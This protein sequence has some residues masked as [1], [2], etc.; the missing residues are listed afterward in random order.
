M[1]LNKAAGTPEAGTVAPVSGVPALQVVALSKRFG[2]VVALDGVSFEVKKGSIHALVGE[3][4]A[5]KSTLVKI[6]AGATLADSGEI[7]IF[8][9]ATGFK[10]PGEAHDHGL[11]LV[12]Q[13][14]TVLPPRSVLANLFVNREP[15]GW[16]GVS[17]RRM[18]AL[19]QPVLEQLGLSGLDLDTPASALAIADQ[20]LLEIAKALIL[21]PKV[22]LLDE[23]N[24]ALNRQ[25]TQRLFTILRQLRADGNTMIYVSHRL[26]EVLEICDAVTVLRNGRTISTGPTRG[27]SVANL[28]DAMLG[29][30]QTELFPPKPDTIIST[31]QCLQVRGVIVPGKIEAFNLEAGSGELIGIAG[32]EG[33]GVESVLPALFGVLPAQGGEVRMPDGRPLPQN[34]LSAAQRR[35]AYIPPDRRRQGLMLEKSIASNLAQV[36]LGALGSPLRS[37]PA[38]LLDERA[39]S[40]IRQLAIK[41]RSPTTPAQHLSG[42][43]Q[44][45]VVV[46][47]W[48]QTNPELILLDDPARGVD[49]GAKRELFGLVRQ[50]QATGKIVLMR[51]TEL[52]ELVG[53][54]DRI[55]VFYRGRIVAEVDARQTN[56]KSL[57]ECINTGVHPD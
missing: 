33:S 17:K 7:H 48:L 46:G 39:L 10:T 20:Q 23:P 55:I 49:V 22:L 14:L 21:S 9:S 45:K 15:S 3:N 51:S 11:A 36:S 18:A 52:S 41:T 6:L 12:H 57:L 16:F 54:C 30:S 8:G 44:Q 34:P 4:G 5:G 47:K 31:S 40:T 13:E 43:N 2:G 53:L 27:L 28:V 38:G 37:H 24:S 29:R 25:E 35:I 32:L 1:P 42:G 19:A 56:E 26:E 50:M